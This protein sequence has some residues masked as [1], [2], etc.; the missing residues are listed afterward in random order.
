MFR[1]NRITGIRSKLALPGLGALAILIVLMEFLWVPWQ[2]TSTQTEIQEEQRRILQ[3]LSPALVEP[4]LPGDLGQLYSTLDSVLLSDD[5]WHWLELRNINKEKLYPLVEEPATQET[6]VVISHVV[7]YEGQPHGTL[8]LHYD[9][10][11]KLAAKTRQIQLVAIVVFSV[12]LL[13]LML[14]F[15]LQDLLI[16]KPAEG[17]YLPPGVCLKAISISPF[18]RTVAMRSVSWRAHWT[19]CG[20][21]YSRLPAVFVIRHSRPRPLSTIWSMA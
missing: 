15:L 1:S 4:L 13:T 7:E 8:T 11:D 19:E 17:W 2:V 12:F 16:R 14:S 5:A 20:M 21:N 10:S 3:T 9:A 6:Q 18:R